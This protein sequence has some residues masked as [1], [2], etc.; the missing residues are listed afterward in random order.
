MAKS[1]LPEYTAWKNMKARCYN[2]KSASYLRYGGRGI[3]VC[4]RWLESFEAFLTDLG[5]RPKGTSLDRIDS[6]DHYRPG[7]CR[8]ASAKTQANNRKKA[9][10]NPVFG[11]S[12]K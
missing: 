2:E 6:N 1:Q 12:S 8:W 7:N 11:Y 5:K 9:L 3:K 4:S 10:H